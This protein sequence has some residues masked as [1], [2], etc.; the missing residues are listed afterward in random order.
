[1]RN[2]FLVT[3]CMSQDVLNYHWTDE[4]DGKPCVTFTGGWMDRFV[5]ELQERAE[6]KGSLGSLLD[7]LLQC[8]DHGMTSLARVERGATVGKA[9]YGILRCACFPPFPSEMRV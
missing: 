3:E 8:L 1:M 5:R 2:D 6:Q 4:R 7:P 9:I